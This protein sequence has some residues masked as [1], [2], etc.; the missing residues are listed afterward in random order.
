MWAVGA[1]FGILTRQRPLGAAL[2]VVPW[3]FAFTACLALFLLLGTS[4]YA[5]A[6]RL[7]P[8]RFFGEISY[9]LYL[10]HLLIFDA[11]DGLFRQLGWEPARDS[12]S[13]AALAV[14]F[15][16]VS[17]VATPLAFLSR[18]YF[19]ERFLRFKSRWT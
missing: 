3:H 12:G 19:E 7:R 16:V 9:G 4:Q 8:L 14:R 15:L 13:L 6:V 1:P 18:K 11:Y 2:Q 5:A 17:A 10:V